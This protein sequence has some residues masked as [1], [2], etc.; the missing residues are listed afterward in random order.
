MSLTPRQTALVAC[1]RNLRQPFVLPRASA[2]YHTCAWER[3][4]ID[5]YCCTLCSSVHAC[6]ESTCK[7]I[8]E[9]EDGTVCC[10]SGIALRTI[11]FVEDEFVEHIH[12]TDFKQAASLFDEETC[13]SEIEQC[14]RLLLTS[15]VTQRLYGKAMLKRMEKLRQSIRT[16]AC[17]LGVCVHFL[18]E[19]KAQQSLSFGLAARENMVH[20]CVADCCRVMRTL[21]HAFGMFL[22]PSDTMNIAA[23]T[24]YLMRAGVHVHGLSIVPHHTAL[25]HMLPPEASLDEY[26]GLRAKSITDA[27]NQ[28]KF[29]LRKVTRHQLLQAG[30]KARQS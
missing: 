29:C 9:T 20:V 17:M 12:L 26:F 27:E 7:D 10:L 15:N 6:S 4:E 5:L 21:V 14:V 16:S 18:Q 8:V 2:P 13:S 22:K 28:I 25:K 11:R 24:L 23:G 19:L 30:F 3:I 1:W